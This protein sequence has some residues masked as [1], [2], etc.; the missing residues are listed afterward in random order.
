MGSKCDDVSSRLL[1]ED[2]LVQIGLNADN[3]YQGNQANE[4]SC[5]PIRCSQTTEKSSIVKPLFDFRMLTQSQG[6]CWQE[7]SIKNMCELIQPLNTFKLVD[8]R[9]VVVGLQPV[10]IDA[11]SRQIASN[12]SKLM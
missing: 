10:L 2:F 12:R 11:I 5:S 6:S 9:G 3:N 4:A 7:L 1:T 8:Q